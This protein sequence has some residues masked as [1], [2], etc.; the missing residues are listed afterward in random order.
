MTDTSAQQALSQ[1]FQDQFD[2]ELPSIETDLIEAGILD[3]LMLIEL[4]MFMES[5]FDVT[6]ELDD[7][8]ME[9][10]VTVARM[11]QFIEARRSPSGQDEAAATA[12]QGT[13]LGAQGG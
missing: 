10:F 1:F 5:E 2:I 13:A 6:A 7:L 8:E 4:V 3:S 12:G 11:A 9:N